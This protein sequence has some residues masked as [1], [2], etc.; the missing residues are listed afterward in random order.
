MMKKFKQ[1]GLV[2]IYSQSLTCFV[3]NFPSVKR[4]LIYFFEEFT[5]LQRTHFPFSP[6]ND[7]QKPKENRS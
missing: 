3:A 6:K 4:E 2:I 1:V 7:K 5:L